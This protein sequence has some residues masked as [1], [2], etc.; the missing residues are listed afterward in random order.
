MVNIT[1][2]FQYPRGLLL[3]YITNASLD[4]TGV[5]K[6]A[7]LDPS[8]DLGTLEQV[9]IITNYGYTVP[10]K[11][12]DETVVVDGETNADANAETAVD[13]NADTAA[14]GA[15]TADSPAQ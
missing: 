12:A 3:G 5:A 6:Y 7:T 4:E 2:I 15:N 1:C 14:D 8:C 9:F 10:E 13:A 11:R